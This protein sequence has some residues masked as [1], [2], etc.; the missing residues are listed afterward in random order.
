MSSVWILYFYLIHFPTR[1]PFAYHI[2]LWTKEEIKFPEPKLSRLFWG[3]PMMFYPFHFF[4]DIPIRRLKVELGRG[5]T[6]LENVEDLSYLGNFFFR[7]NIK[8][9]YY[10]SVTFC[11][12]SGKFAG[13]AELVLDKSSGL[14]GPLMRRGYKVS[15][16]DCKWPMVHE[17]SV[18]QDAI[19]CK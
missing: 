4:Q 13:P 12:L 19:P 17:L 10:S 15:Y 7:K 3:F 9:W 11:S 18:K 2:Y 8:N 5:K 6:A 14:M 16:Y 1:S